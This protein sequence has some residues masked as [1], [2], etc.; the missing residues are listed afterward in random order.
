M[1][2]R[3]SSQLICNLRLFC[4]CKS[5]D[6]ACVLVRL[7][8]SNRGDAASCDIRAHEF[9]SGAGSALNLTRTLMG[10]VETA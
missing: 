10:T 8:I 7:Q 3:P 2:S 5:L 4:R 6:L 1:F 9:G